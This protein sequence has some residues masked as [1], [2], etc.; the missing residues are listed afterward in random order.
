MI[1]KKNL[2]KFLIAGS[3]SI[4]SLTSCNAYFDTL[5][6]IGECCFGPH[7][8]KRRI[9]RSPCPSSTEMV[10]INRKSFSDSVRGAPD[11]GVHGA[12]NNCFSDKRCREK[13]SSFYEFEMEFRNANRSQ[14]YQ[15]N[16]GVDYYCQP[17]R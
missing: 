11:A 14:D 3:L 2:A 7:W 6:E 15:P 12:W 16:P 5:E 17:K 10:V 13:Y 1:L 8:P 9:K 4:T